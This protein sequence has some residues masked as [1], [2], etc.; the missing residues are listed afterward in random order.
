MVMT[1]SFTH[2]SISFS[3]QRFSNCN[4]RV[5]VGFVKVTLDSFCGNKVFE[6]NIQL[7][8]H[9]CDFSKQSFSMYDN[10]FLPVL[11]FVH[12]SSSLM[13]SSHDSCMPTLPQ[14]L[15]DTPDNVTV[16][17][18]DVPAKRAPVIDPLSKSDKSP[19][20][21]FFHKDSHSTQPLMH[22]PR[23]TECIQTEEHP[24]LPTEVLST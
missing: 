17:V 7:C 18:T 12:C 3:N 11:T 24:V 22:C 15:S 8:C 10:F 23:T 9:L 14:K 5:D 4:L 1:P 2:M 13:L 20:F 6:M 21:L 19:I 16:F